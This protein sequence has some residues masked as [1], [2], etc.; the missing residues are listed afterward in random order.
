MLLNFYLKVKLVL[1]STKKNCLWQCFGLRLDN[2]EFFFN[3]K[4]KDKTRLCDFLPLE[5][6]RCMAAKRADYFNIHNMFFF[7]QPLSKNL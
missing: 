5:D 6:Q 7:P 1:N 3:L 2:M 4:V